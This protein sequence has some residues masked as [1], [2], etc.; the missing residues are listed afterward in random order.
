MIGSGIAGLIHKSVETE[1]GI[2]EDEQD[3]N[4]Y[5]EFAV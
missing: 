1:R 2:N 5:G 3:S 4:W